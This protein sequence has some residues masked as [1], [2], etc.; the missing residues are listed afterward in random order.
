MTEFKG[1][2]GKMERLNP[3]AHPICFADPNRLTP[4]SAW[5]EHI[6]FA[7]F[8]VDI[9][10]P[11]VIV[12]LG[13]HYGDSY[14]AFCQAVKELGLDTRCYA[15]DTWRGDPHTGFYG[16][17]VLADLRAHHDPL[18]ISKLTEDKDFADA[19]GEIEGALSRVSVQYN[20]N[21]RL[22]VREGKGV[23]R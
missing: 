1:R 2:S 8:L 20:L 17:E 19:H 22:I 12:E 11:K 6:P 18:P 4:H 15:I 9:L 16:S 5:R 14:C 7:M 10:R 23:L 21:I 3:F 13:T